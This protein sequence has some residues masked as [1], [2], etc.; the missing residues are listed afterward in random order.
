[1]IEVKKRSRDDP[2]RPC[3]LENPINSTAAIRYLTLHGYRIDNMLNDQKLNE[4]VMDLVGDLFFSC[5]EEQIDR[6]LMCAETGDL[7]GIIATIRSVYSRLKMNVPE[8]IWAFVAMPD[9][10]NEYVR[11][12]SNQLSIL[13]TVCDTEDQIYEL[14]EYEE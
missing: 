1:M 6:F 7:K 14:E 5:T 9:M 12:V 2:A 4:A 13:S 10:W 8:K 11:R 3:T